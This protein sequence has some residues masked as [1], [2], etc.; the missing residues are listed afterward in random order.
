MPNLTDQYTQQY[1][2]PDDSYQSDLEMRLERLRGTAPTAP[3]QSKAMGV[4]QKF[5]LPALAVAETIATKQTPAA[6][7]GQMGLIE[8]REQEAQR[9]YESQLGEHTRQTERL[10]DILRGERRGALQR[11]M[12]EWEFEQAQAEA[13]R[14]EEERARQRAYREALGGAEGLEA[15]LD[16]M[17]QYDPAGALKYRVELE[18]AR[19]KREQ[20]LEGRPTPATQAVNLGDT[21]SSVTQ[22]DKLMTTAG[23]AGVSF[24]PL[25][26][27]QALNPWATE[28]QAMQQLTA[29]TKQLIGKGLEGGVL[30]K[31]DEYKYE[32]II[33]KLGDTRPVL[34]RKYNQLRD[35]LANKYMSTRQA[36]GYAGFDVSGFP[37]NVPQTQI[38]ILEPDK[39]IYRSMGPAA[40]GGAPYTPVG[41]SITVRGQRYVKARPGPDSDKDT[42][43]IA[44]DIQL[45]E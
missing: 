22:L 17:K 15:Q 37:E 4:Y 43:Q 24:T 5:I 40:G 26:K 10:E 31:E 28:H 12:G 36:L 9:R 1:V 32:K 6:A 8:S 35:M 30:R 7:L 38:S 39:P 20:D 23:E 21:L 18:K 29:A 41:E 25:D 3:E 16:V 33:P 45:E 44:Y 34:Q 14:E 2:F 11:Q 19:Q 27:I 13:T 42:W